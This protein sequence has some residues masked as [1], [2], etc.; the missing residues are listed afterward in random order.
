MTRLIHFVRYSAIVFSLA[1]AGQF[2]VSRAQDSPDYETVNPGETI[3]VG[4]DNPVEWPN[5]QSIVEAIA[6]II[7]VIAIPI[8]TFMIIYSGILFLTSRGDP[9]KLAK[10]KVNFTWTLV[11][12]F[13]A[14]SVFAIIKTFERFL[15]EKTLV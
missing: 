15:F 4:I 2:S 3:T 5:L 10:A 14:I 6:N 8:G 13:I 12:L 11:G 7:Q 1:I 9:Q